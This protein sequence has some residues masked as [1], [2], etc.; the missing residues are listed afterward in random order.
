VIARLEAGSAR[1]ARRPRG[2]NYDAVIEVMASHESRPVPL[3]AE[4]DVQARRV[5]E[6]ICCQ[7]DARSRPSAPRS[8]RSHLDELAA[9]KGPGTR[10]RP[11]RLRVALGISDEAPTVDQLQRDRDRV[12]IAPS[13]PR[14]NVDAREIGQPH[15]INHLVGL[16]D[17]E[18]TPSRTR[19]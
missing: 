16:A 6:S 2:H 8:P 14:V 7:S 5:V 15:W 1:P 4:R 18:D 3:K 9:D 12:S 19:L 17:A 10:C 13:H 11:E